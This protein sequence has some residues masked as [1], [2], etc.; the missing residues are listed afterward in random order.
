MSRPWVPWSPG[1][2]A[3]PPPPRGSSVLRNTPRHKPS[4]HPWTIGVPG[5]TATKWASSILAYLKLGCRV[6]TMQQLAIQ[7]SCHVDMVCAQS[8]WGSLVTPTGG[9]ADSAVVRAM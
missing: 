6:T 3:P 7:I 4:H 2:G 5:L 9:A 8:G 1:C